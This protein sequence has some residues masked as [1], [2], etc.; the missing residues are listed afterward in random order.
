[1]MKPFP[2]NRIGAVY[3]IHVARFTE[4]ATHMKAQLGRFE[5]P[6][7]FVLP[8]DAETLDADA[9]RRYLSPGA[10]ITVGE[11][12]CVLKH[13]EAMRRIAAKNHRLALVLE[14]DVLLAENF[15]EQLAAILEKAETL[16][17]PFTIQIGCANNM[18]VPKTRLQSGKRLYQMNQVRAT[19]SYLINAAAA[20][21]RLE[22]LEQNRFDRPAGHLF[23]LVDNLKQ[24]PIYWSEPTIVE[25]GSMNGMFRSLLASKR[26]HKPLWILKWRFA[27]SRLRKKYLRRFF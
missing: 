10:R 19:D 9:Q 23:N 22:W 15:N 5:I 25:Q 2:K 27:W 18:Y 14:D 17:S 11:L 8:Y 4:R 13:M 20:R 26:R 12:S 24:I 21:L 16:K 3:V 1:M 6:F 7:E